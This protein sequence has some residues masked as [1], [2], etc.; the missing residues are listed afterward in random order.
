M[1][2]KRSTK[3]KPGRAARAGSSAKGSRRASGT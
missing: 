3:K 2:K 1:A